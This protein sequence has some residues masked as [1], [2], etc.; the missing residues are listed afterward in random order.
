MA[1]SWIKTGTLYD[2][3]YTA[4]GNRAACTIDLDRA[5]DR[6]V[7]HVNGRKCVDDVYY[8]TNAKKMVGLFDQNGVFRIPTGLRQP[9]GGESPRILLNDGGL[10]DEA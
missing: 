7:I 2:R 5:A 8:V 1:L 4:R 10:H 6:W 9:E 3:L